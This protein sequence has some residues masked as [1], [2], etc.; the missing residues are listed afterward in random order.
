MI[1]GIILEKICKINMEY[2]L[3]ESLTNVENITK[4]KDIKGKLKK[5]K[6]IGIAIRTADVSEE[7][8]QEIE[9][10]VEK[11]KVTLNDRIEEIREQR[12]NK[13]KI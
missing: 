7:K 8:K 6:E 11:G 3:L 4:I 12:K 1:D 9:E 2:M 10:Y 13:L 5:I